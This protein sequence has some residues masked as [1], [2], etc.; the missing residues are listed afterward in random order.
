M[1]NLHSQN[2]RILRGQYNIFKRWYKWNYSGVITVVL[3][4]ILV[5]GGLFYWQDNQPFYNNWSCDTLV[6][7]VMNVDVPDQ[8]PKHNELTEDQ[9]NQVHQFLDECQENNRFSAP[10]EHLKNQ[11]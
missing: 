7:Y 8:F 10:I 11:G 4:V 5:F 6:D 3:G 1:G 9:H 2:E